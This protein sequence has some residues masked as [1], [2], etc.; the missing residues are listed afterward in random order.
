VPTYTAISGEAIKYQITPEAAAFLERL[1]M[2]AADPAVNVHQ[3]LAL[4][5]SDE[6][7]ILDRNFVAGRAMV[8]RA[9]FDNPVWWI[10]SDLIGAKRVQLGLLDIDAAKAAYTISVNEAAE[11]LGITPSSVRS[12]IMA[13]KLSAHMR[14]GQWYTRPE[15]IASY[16]VSNRGRKKKDKGQGVEM[17]KVIHVQTNNKIAPTVRVRTGNAPGVSLAIKVVGGDKLVRMQGDD[18]LLPNGWHRAIVRTT[19]TTPKGKAVRVFEIEPAA[20]VGTIDVGELY[21]TG[22]FRIAKK[23]NN[24][25]QATE[26]WKAASGSQK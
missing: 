15:A 11:Q 6:N 1:R 14:N 18:W 2:A 5:Y 9:V 25:K 17:P 16:K 24:G 12:A 8:T 26:A 23:I 22:A 10:M 7:P 20:E 19:T 3:F 13:R 21:V 4:V